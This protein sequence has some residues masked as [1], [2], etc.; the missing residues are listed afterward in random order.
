LSSKGLSAIDGAGTDGSC[1]E[2]TA[3]LC[4]V[5]RASVVMVCHGSR[6]L[7][8]LRRLA[9]IS[10][11][12]TGPEGTALMP[13]QVK[14][15]LVD[16]VRALRREIV[17]AS[18]VAKD[19]EVQFKLGPIELEFAVEMSRETG[20]DGGLRFWVVSLGGQVKTGSA[21]THTVRLALTPA[22]GDV[23]ILDELDEEPE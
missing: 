4:P 7:R 2:A 16:A 3:A 21:T 19:E 6:R 1:L 17:E 5:A 8:A 14:I 9:R 18:R 20:V 15:P 10:G 23:L 11:S 13:E 22:G 12:S